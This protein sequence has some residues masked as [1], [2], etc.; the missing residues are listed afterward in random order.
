MNGDV[1]GKGDTILGKE[2]RV[3]RGRAS[4]RDMLPCGGRGGARIYV[5]G[6]AE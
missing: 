5:C 4:P 3:E 1:C 6:V 2:A